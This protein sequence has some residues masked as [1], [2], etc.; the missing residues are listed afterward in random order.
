MKR[1]TVLLG[2]A[3]ALGALAIGWS[4]LP[5]RQRLLTSRALPAVAGTVAL[6]G[7]VRIGADDSIA[8]VVCKTEMGQGAHTGLAMLLAEELDADW[9]R[10][11][12]EPAPIDAIYNNLV[13][14]VE[15]LPFHPDDDGP[16]KS[17]AGWLTAKT[18]REVGV[19]MTGGSSSIKDLWL[20]VREAGA[21]ARAMLVGAAAAQWNVPAGECTVV[22]GKVMHAS[23]SSAGF[24]ELVASAAAQPLPRKPALK[25]PARFTLIGQPLRRI[26]APAKL[27]GSA[28][29]GIDVLPPG[30]QYASVVMCPTLGGSVARF[31]ANPALALPGV[32]KVI[33]LPA[34]RGTSGG[35]AA[36]ADTPYQAMRAAQS[37]KVEWDQGPGSAID[38]DT[39]YRTLAQALDVETGFAFYRHGDVDAA[40]ASATK[41]ISAEYRAP[42]LAHAAL[43]PMNCTVQ[44]KDGR[45]TVWASTQ[46]PGIAR[47]A[48]AQVLGIDSE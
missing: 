8:I 26:E 38:S 6:N 25:D 18:M 36:I 17:L 10:V 15:G 32:T 14:T 45:A 35:I 5:P 4:V 44:F 34:L 29:F 48:V 23:G 24:G 40:M 3:G 46:V 37:V 43:E 7:W 42:Y 19:M 39:V 12:V 13:A 22:K 9:S 21:S 33:A 47:S 31:D 28:R 30:L 41:K 20:P 27:D 16:L 11:H 1:R 2:G